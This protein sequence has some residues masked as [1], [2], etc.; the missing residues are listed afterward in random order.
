MLQ[1]S[2]QTVC[3]SWE[4]YGRDSCGVSKHDCLGRNFKSLSS[5]S[6]QCVAK[7]A[8]SADLCEWIGQTGSPQTIESDDIAPAAFS[9]RA[10][11]EWLPPETQDLKCCCG[12]LHGSQHCCGSCIVYSV[13]SVTGPQKLA[14]W[15]TGKNPLAFK[16]L[17]QAKQY[18]LNSE[19]S[20]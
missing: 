20:D 4:S 18:L 13:W 7:Q 16:Q 12:D 8:A 1:L 3:F 17:L 10:C 15:P 11:R 14:G 9:W 19:L 5:Y 2:K 6:V